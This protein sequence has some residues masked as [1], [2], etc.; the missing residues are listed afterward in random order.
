M[1]IFLLRCF[2]V[3]LSLFG[4]PLAL[5]QRE[6]ELV[7][8]TL[9]LAP[10]SAQ[11]ATWP[12]WPAL[13]IL[14][15]AFTEDTEAKLVLRGLSADLARTLSQRLA[16]HST[17]A[18]A[19][20]EPRRLRLA[21]DPALLARFSPEELEVWHRLLASNVANLGSRW[22]L[23]VESSSLAALPDHDGGLEVLALLKRFALPSPDGRFWRLHDPWLLN[24]ALSQ[25]RDRDALL[26]HLLSTHAVWVKV[27][28]GGTD[29][30]IVREDAAYWQSHR[31][32]RAI[33]PILQ[34]LGAVTD[35]DRIDLIH[36]IPRVPRALINSF[37]LALDRM[38]DPSE[39]N[40]QAFAGFFGRHPHADAMVD[41]SSW[42]QAH[43][44]P[45]DGARAFGDA[46]V[47]EDPSRTRWP[48]TA[49]YIADG[50]VFGRR[51]TLSGPWGLWRI[52]E[53]P[54]VNPRLAA[55]PPRTYRL[56]AENV[57]FNDSF[58]PIP[59][60]RN[61]IRPSTLRPLAAGP[62]GRLWTYDIFLAPSASLLAQLPEPAFE[63]TWP[64]R[65]FDAA[66]RESL[67]QLPAL[68]RDQREAL[69]R[70]F[71]AAQPSPDG[72]ML[73]HPSPDLVA[74][75]PPT[76][77]SEAYRFLRGGGR[78][79]DYFQEIRVIQPLTSDDLPASV[80]D[81]LLPL[82]YPR[83]GR[84]A[85]GDYGLV[86]HLTQDIEERVAMLQAL[87]R[88]PA[89]IVLL[90]RP[91]PEEVPALTAYWEAGGRKDLGLLLEAFAEQSTTTYLDITHLL[92]PLP[93]EYMNHFVRPFLDQAVP[94]CYWTALNFNRA[95]PDP[96]FLV[97]P[98]LPGDEVDVIAQELRTNYIE[99]EAPT[100]LGD[101]IAYYD[102]DNPR[103]PQHVC[104]AIA[105]D[106][107]FTK[108][109]F[110][111][112]APWCLTPR[113]E[114]D[115]LYLLRRSGEVRYYRLKSSD[116]PAVSK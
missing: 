38:P 55:S 115:D 8:S 75:L 67:L 63:P 46:I 65:R 12:E 70:A 41:L 88:T 37:P 89:R 36:L 69:R 18:G 26:R 56:R 30:D 52:D 14:P 111:Y 90:E 103:A 66:L 39:D 107:V 28:T 92:A 22:P 29:F 25:S 45:I 106:L 54:A 50:L 43:C 3:I 110:G 34:A 48:F 51:P 16:P 68:N 58:T 7:Q 101:V 40:A 35:R 76:W 20:S 4:P 112:D 13:W 47:F 2:G 116:Q 94:S 73:V 61:W 53:L 99:I 44:D 100:R 23:V 57:D 91:T 42:L 60:P 102:R 97:N 15:S 114:I 6:P 82:I 98:G 1:R 72:T 86:Y 93:R 62:W 21:P 74:T 108:N 79:T 10:T 32:Y 109:G 31:R 17:N 96:R 77:R 80:A 49:I 95:L 59:P 83:N 84:F 78:V 9:R 5:G 71:A 105:A 87:S 27:L 24:H 19:S 81:G 11:T 85:V 33:E 104:S 113:Q 64:F